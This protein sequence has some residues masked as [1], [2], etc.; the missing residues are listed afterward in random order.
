M[1]SLQNWLFTGI[2]DRQS[3]IPASLQSA[4]IP[5]IG[6][7]RC[8]RLYDLQVPWIGNLRHPRLYNL[9]VPWIGNL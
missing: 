6:N 3:A 5:R 8:P 2:A 4:G 9:Q 7:L 1:F